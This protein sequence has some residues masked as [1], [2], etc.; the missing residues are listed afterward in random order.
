MLV[1][2]KKKRFILTDLQGFLGLFGSVAQQ[3]RTA[4]SVFLA[5]WVVV[6]RLYPGGGMTMPKIRFRLHS[7]RYSSLGRNNHVA[8]PVVPHTTITTIRAMMRLAVTR[9][10]IPNTPATNIAAKRSTTTR[11]G[12]IAMR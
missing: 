9:R 11:M 2:T 10:V 12:P 7:G 4:A 8:K 6:C 5:I 1:A 3:W